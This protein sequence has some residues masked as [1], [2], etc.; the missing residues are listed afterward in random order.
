MRSAARTRVVTLDSEDVR[1][2]SVEDHVDDTLSVVLKLPE[3]YRD[4]VYLHYYEG[5]PT[6]EI[7]QVVGSPPSTVRN[8]LRDARK[9]L[10]QMLGDDE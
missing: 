6:D 7:A 4:V 10:R 9:L 2:P 1:E 3:K 8:R 5:M